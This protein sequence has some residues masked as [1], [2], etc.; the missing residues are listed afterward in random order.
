MNT[1]NHTPLERVEA[2]LDRIESKLDVHLDRVSRAETNIA[3]LRGHV[4]I[5]TAIFLSTVGFLMTSLWQYI[6]PAK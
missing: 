4:Q 5:A 3:W 6:F 2:R 1:E